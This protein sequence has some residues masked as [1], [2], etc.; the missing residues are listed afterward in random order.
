VSAAR[1]SLAALALAGLLGVTSGACGV[2][3][4]G[5]FS[6]I[7]PRDIPPQ[8]TATTATTTT[9][10]STTTTVAV[11][12]ST[13][14]TIADTTTTAVVPAE[15][16]TMYFVAG[17]Y[18]VSYDV[19]VR[20]DVSV[21]E[22]LTLLATGLEGALAAG[23]RTAIPP[24]SNNVATVDPR[25]LVTVNLDP[26]FFLRMEDR[27]DQTLAI[28]QIVLTLT[29]MRGISQVRF[30]QNGDDIQVLLADG[31]ASEIGQVLYHTDY[32]RLLTD[33]PP[34]VTVPP[35]TSTTSTTTALA[36]VATTTTSR[37]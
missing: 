27:A 11:A 28:A 20:R 23:L 8:L 15:L 7:D 36:Q 16:M 1:R 18:I 10:L 14:T 21:P 34:E 3:G 4:S 17:R 37:G 12:E 30:T 2:P 5:R 33:L 32:A 25:G 24:G 22:V 9:V 26:M 35:T 13:T 31:S 29:T 19:S 6:A